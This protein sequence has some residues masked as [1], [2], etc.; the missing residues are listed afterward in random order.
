MQDVARLAGV[1]ATTV[2]HVINNTRPVSAPTRQAVEEAVA[3][4][5]Y[6]PN[7]IARSLAT[8]STKSIGLVLPTLHNPALG[9]LAV[10]V[11]TAA[12]ANDYTMMLTSTDDDADRELAILHTLRRRRVDGILLAS[13]LLPEQL[14]DY[15]AAEPGPPAPMVLI[16]RLPNP[17]L[18]QVGVEN[19]DATAHLV[20]HLVALGHRRIAIVC[21]LPDL[22]TTTERIDGYKSGLARHGIPVVRSLIAGAACREPITESTPREVAR[23]LALPAP[24]TALIGGNGH[25]TAEILRA[26]RD[27]GRR[28]PDD[29]VVVG[30]DDVAWADLLPSPLTAIAQPWPEIGRLATQI[31]L[32]RIGG[33]TTPHQTTRLAPRLVHRESCGCRRAQLAV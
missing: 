25:V 31:L 20:D 32:A 23:L 21:G 17:A 16:D 19:H 7:A 3:A 5:G 33:D 4:T 29:I 6:V 2:S 22:S 26:L 11:E 15:L 1:S 8:A 27:H 13:T 24:P 18:D 10:A 14:A 28:V 12:R 30:F 9:E